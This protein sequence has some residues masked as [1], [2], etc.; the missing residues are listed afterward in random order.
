MLQMIKK[1][2]I[3]VRL[4]NDNLKYEVINNGYSWISQG[5]KPHIIFQRKIFNKNIWFYKSFSWAKNK[6]H[7]VID[8]KI[9]SSYS[10]FSIL[11]KKL[12][13]RFQTT[14]E[15]CE[16]N[17]VNFSIEA[18]NEEG[19]NFK[20]VSFPQPFNA[21][22]Y[23][24]NKAY[25]VDPRRQ[26]FIL[27]DTYKKNRK[28]IFL[29]TKYWRQLN[30]GEAYMPLWGRVCDKKGYVAYSENA[31][32]L[33]LFSSYGKDKAFLTASNWLGSLGKL[34]YK[35]EL[36]MRFYDECN[37]VTFAKEYRENLIKNNNFITIDDKI[38]RNSN[39]SKLIGSPIIHWRTLENR[40]PKSKGYKKGK[41]NRILHN[42]FY[43]SAKI[44]TKFKELGLEKAYVHL[45]GWGKN[46]YDNL[47][48]Y[49]LPPSD[50]AG[51]YQGLKILSDTCQKLGYV[52]ALHD[53]YRD[54]YLD[55]DAYDTEKAIIN[56]N[57]KKL[58]CDEWDGGAH[59]LLCSS[60]ALDYVK[61]TYETLFDNDIKVNGVYLDVFSIAP[62]DECY[63]RHHL[64]TR[65]QS[66]EY[67]RACF[68][69]L[70]DKG[71]IVSSEEPGHQMINELDI[72][73]HAP[74]SITPQERGEGVGVAIPLLNLVYHECVFIPWFVDGKGG[75]G[76]PDN[77]EGKLHCILNGQSPYFSSS[78]D[79][80]GQKENTKQIMNR[81]KNVMEIAKITKDLYN[82]EMIDHK[83]LDDSYRLQQTTF[84]NGVEITV[85]FDTG[86]YK[87]RGKNNE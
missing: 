49:I 42:D 83:F 22:S 77:D 10:G 57:G 53:Q 82:A 3:E 16:N 26:G 43:Q 66:I 6:T 4:L 41:V 20:C 68:K 5:R 80:T 1:G 17:K 54:F 59:N 76:I 8:N 18:F 50:D 45:D 34:S 31:Y 56:I 74:Y 70:R 9:V 19:E 71:I 87:I 51:G 29:I 67:R 78:M 84:S 47:H 73:H 79:T 65:K 11:G 14:V 72:V 24:V 25:S 35:R 36:T 52:F 64:T 48:P 38:K 37:Y 55:S 12:N 23:D 21:K 2:S 40:K 33:S 85:N 63:N 46:G 62:G 81:I 7:E 58:Y 30:S 28:E 27:P 60:F 13:V 69:W 75:W 44:F 61:K 15:I 86:E 32:D 39:V